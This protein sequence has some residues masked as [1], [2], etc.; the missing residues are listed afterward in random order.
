[1]GL[2]IFNKSS[3]NILQ[4][5]DQNQM[6]KLQARIKDTYGRNINDCS[7][8]SG[9]FIKLDRVGGD[10][11]EEIFEKNDEFINEISKNLKKDENLKEIFSSFDG[12]FPALL[13]NKLE[14]LSNYYK[15]MENLLLPYKKSD[16]NPIKSVAIKKDDLLWHT[17][18]SIFDSL[19]ELITLLDKVKTGK[20]KNR[21]KLYVD[22]W[23]TSKKF[24]MTIF[25]SIFKTCKDGFLCE[26][27][28]KSSNDVF[29]RNTKET[30]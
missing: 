17:K 22:F 30:Q 6:N 11:F 19:T 21:V 14:K 8:F 2:E 18:E 5:K 16:S 28:I 25:N 20:G 24:K 1:L 9:S 13:R 7:H 29:H 15:N 26:Y 3:E 23:A 4:K 27:W 12:F 10:E